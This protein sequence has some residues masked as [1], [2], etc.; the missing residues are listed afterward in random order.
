[1]QEVRFDGSK[2]PIKLFDEKEMK[3]SLA[4]PEVKEVRVFKLRAGM[5]ININDNYF[6]VN[7]ISSNGNAMLQP[8]PNPKRPKHSVQGSVLEE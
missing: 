3:R 8:I 5:K 4:K 1:M 6:L 7:H 2:G